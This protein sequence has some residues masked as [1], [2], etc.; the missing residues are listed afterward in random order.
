MMHSLPKVRGRLQADFDLS[1]LSWLRVGGKAQVLFQPADSD[2]LRGFLRDLSADIPVFTI[3]VCSNL[4]IRDGGVKG[5][6]IRLGRGFNDVEVLADCQIRA[7]AGVLD[8][9]VAKR[10][11]EAGIDLAFLRTIPGSIGGAVKMNAG[12]YGRYIADV[13]MGGEG[14]TRT[15]ETITLTRSDIDFAYRKTN[16]PDGF[17]VTSAILQGAADSPDA[18]TAKMDSALAKRSE[19]QPIDM[20]SC[21]S[22]FRNPAGYSS[23]GAIDDPNTLKAWKLIEDAGLRGA[24]LGG[25]QMS[26]K[27]CNFL[28]NTGGATAHDLEKLGND[29]QKKVF[30]STGIMLEWE[31]ERIGEA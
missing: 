13:F 25:A 28:V 26:P 12:C 3:G 22:T 2:D 14:V 21:G 18:I 19:T 24:T 15:G 30:K 7:G 27:H 8:S 5:V 17:I 23:T 4:I 20:R 29:I 16:L 10:A 9:I 31:I 1:A 6:V 11:A